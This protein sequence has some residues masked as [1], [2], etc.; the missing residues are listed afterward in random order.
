MSG[1]KL[2]RGSTCFPAALLAVALVLSAACSAAFGQCIE[3]CRAI[4]TFVGEARGDMLGWKTNNVGDLT[5]DGVNDVVITA[6]GH[7]NN[8][9]KIYVYDS[10]NGALL[11][12]AVGAPGWRLGVDA[13]GVGD[14]NDDTVPDVI[15]GAPFSGTGRAILYSGADGSVLHTFPGEQSAAEFGHRVA[16]AGDVNGDGTPDILITARRHDLGPSADVGR[17]YLYSGVD[18]ALLCTIDG[19][20]AGDQFGSGAG[21][22]GDL[23][24]NRRSEIVIGAPN[25]GLNH[26]GRGYVYR[27]DG[28]GC[29]LVHTLDPPG[30]AAGLGSLFA[31]GG[32]D[33]DRDGTPDV[34][35]GD[36]PGNRAHVFS[37]VD[38]RPIL[39]LSG[40]GGFGL[41]ELIEDVNGDGRADLILAAWVSNVGGFQAGQAFVYS[42]RDGSVLQSFTHDVPGAQ[43][44]FDAKG[45]GDVDFDG[46][47]DYVIAAAADGG[48]R[49]KVYIIAG[50][51]LRTPPGDLNCDGAF[52]GGDI[53]PFFLALGD[54][55]AYTAQFPNCDILL[56]D[57]NGDGAVNGGDIDPFFDCLGGG[58]CP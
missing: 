16:G 56:G 50:Q 53:D 19:Q 24:G 35:V 8:S 5:G 45:L 34:Y 43:F 23:D 58:V 54:P 6:P 15:A 32:H 37:G 1:L 46:K 18:F 20:A 21:T 14:V 25:A 55:A 30:S 38:G 49:G 2:R 10:A 9:G 47:A 28:P 17:A 51:I 4:H 31:N 36:F 13:N 40:S 22:A 29:T 42:G 3:G 7:A 33:V 44:G 11:F 52:N 12:D 39:S 41:G 27:F 48:N 26:R 57:M